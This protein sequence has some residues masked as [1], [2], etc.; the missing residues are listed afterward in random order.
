M[1]KKISGD[2]LMAHLSIDEESLVTVIR[3]AKDLL[4][5]Q[6]TAQSFKN[7]GVADQDFWE[8]Y[9][10][11]IDEAYLDLTAAIKEFQQITERLNANRNIDLTNLKRS[12]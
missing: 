3:E 9:A 4:A 8:E 2:K 6:E 12:N 11:E 1:K 7:L 10:D 5:L